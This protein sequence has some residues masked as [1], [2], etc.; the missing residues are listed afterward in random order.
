MRSRETSPSTTAQAWQSPRLSVLGGVSS[1][2][3]TGSMAS[4]ESPLDLCIESINTTGNTC[5]A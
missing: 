5:M 1:L 4:M 2:T 3:E